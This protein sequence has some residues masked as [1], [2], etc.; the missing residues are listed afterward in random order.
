MEEENFLIPALRNDLNIEVVEDDKNKFVVLSDPSNYAPQPVAIPVDLIPL[1]QMLDGT[2][3]TQ[4]IFDKIFQETGQEPDLSPLI[5]LV[6]YLDSMAF[7][8]SDGFKEYKKDIDKYLASP[9]R[10]AF[11][12]GHSYPESPELLKEFLDGIFGSVDPKI[13]TPGAEAIVVP[14]LDF[15]V[16]TEVH[17]A[18]AK[19]YHS[20][21]DTKPELVVIFGTSHYGN[22]D[23]FMLTRKDF[24]TPLGTSV[25]DREIQNELLKKL[26]FEPTFDDMAYRQEHSIEFQVLL[27][28]HY[29]K[30][31]DFK[32]LPVLVGSYQNFITDHI[33]PANHDRFKEF[34]S[35]LNEV[36]GETNRRVIF[37]SSAD[38]AHIGRKFGDDFAAEPEL[39]SLRNED[40]LL[41]N[42]LSEADIGKFYELIAGTNDK[43]K[44]CGLPPIYAMLN[45]ISPGR[46]KLLH[47]GQ[48]SETETES[49]V[50]FA[51]LAFM[52]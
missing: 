1:L 16:G 36:I 48:W 38:F 26:S 6:Y 47:Y 9:V 27:L 11:C 45:T 2:V 51:S 7:M 41:L 32:I 49:A 52:K 25:N 28:Q 13:V 15:R 14:H 40:M 50:T 39:E 23:V 30:G 17:K 34:L 20:I 3:T 5:N 10:D 29:F 12:V 19:G 22:S 21:R 24:S 33:A 31:I 37:I 18:Y 46:G 4:E 44:I 8:Q 35:K 43:R 42:A